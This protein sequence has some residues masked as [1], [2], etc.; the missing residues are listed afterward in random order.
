MVLAS[1]E[2]LAVEEVTIATAPATSVVELLRLPQL[3]EAAGTTTAGHEATTVAVDGARVLPPGTAANVRSLVPMA[4]VESA[5]LPTVPGCG[6]TDS[7]SKVNP[8][9]E[10]RRSSLTPKERPRQ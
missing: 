3:Q 1:E 2:L 8:T 7:T 5:S 9:S 4:V 6:A 10:S